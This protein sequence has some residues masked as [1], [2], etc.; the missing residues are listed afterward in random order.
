V[1]AGEREVDH[2]A[3]R[4]GES[5]FTPGT[6]HAARAIALR[7]GAIA[8][9]GGQHVEQGRATAIVAYVDM[10]LKVLRPRGDPRFA[11]APTKSDLYQLV[12]AH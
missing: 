6:P 11:I 10:S 12:S 1:I 3:H 8:V 9:S 2:R 5:P 4:L 7:C